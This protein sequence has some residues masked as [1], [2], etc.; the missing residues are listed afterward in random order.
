MKRTC[1][2]CEFYAPRYYETAARW[3]NR[4]I[5]ED[6]NGREFVKV[7]GEFIS[8]DELL[9]DAQHGKHIVKEFHYV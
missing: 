4:V 8:V 9:Y 7:Y 2:R 5:Y 3:H 1:R 6:K